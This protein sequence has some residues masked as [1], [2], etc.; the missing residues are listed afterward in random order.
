MRFGHR[1]Q[2]VELAALR[3]LEFVARRTVVDH[4]ALVDDIREPVRHPGIGGQP[5]APG[6]AGFLVVALDV[7][8]QVEVGDEAHVGLVDP[9]AEGDGRDH[10]QPFFAQ[11]AVLVAPPYRAVEPGVVRQGRDAV[12]LEPGC[13]LVDLAAATGS[14][15]CRRHPHARR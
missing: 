14:R 15:R 12:A 7:L 13:G 8:R 11:E 9:H 6:A 10:H 4:A 1:E 2:R 3:A 5:V